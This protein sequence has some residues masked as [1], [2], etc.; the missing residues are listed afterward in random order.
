[1]AGE[2]VVV[3]EATFA[4]EVLKSDRP[5]ILDLWAPWC[6]PCRM[7]EPVLVKLAGERTDVKF[8]K[9]NVDENPGLKGFFNLRS[10]PMVVT[11]RDGNL[12]EMQVGLKGER[13]YRAM[14]DRLNGGGR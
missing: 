8:C 1:M 10:I 2:F 11:M 5:V 13:V 3:T 14:L 6:G 4:S 12:V 9:V 7:L